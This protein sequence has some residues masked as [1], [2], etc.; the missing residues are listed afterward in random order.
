MT[1]DNFT[2]PDAPKPLSPTPAQS[3]GTGPAAVPPA[4]APRRHRWLR[5]L[6]IG[7]GVIVVLLLLLLLLLPTILSSG[8]VRSMVVSKINENLNGHVA[9]SSWKIGWT[10]GVSAD[11]VRVFDDANS[12]ILE[13]NHFSTDVSLIAAARGQIHLGH[14]VVDG[15]DFFAHRYKDGE[16][17]FA[18]L[19]KKSA[20]STTPGSSGGSSSSSSSKLPSI[21]GKVEIT[22]SRG[23]F[24][25]DQTNQTVLIKSLGGTIDIPSINDPIQESLKVVA[26]I[27]AG[28]DGTIT[29]D[30][31]AR[32]ASQ[33]QL[34]PPAQMD[35]QQ[36]LAISSFE[37]AN[38]LP[39]LPKSV[40]V[41]TLA[42]RTDGMINIALAQGQAT[43]S[44][45]VGITG[46][47]AGGQALKG[48]TFAADSLL[49]T[50][51][52]TTANLPGGNPA[53]DQPIRIGSGQNDAITL[54]IVSTVDGKPTQ[55][56]V[57]LSADAT[58]AVLQNVAAMQAPGGSGNVRLTA[59][60]DAR[61]VAGLPHL[62][63][64]SPG[65]ALKSGVV[66]ETLAVTFNKDKALLDE[67]LNVTGVS[68]EDTQ[69]N[70]SQTITLS[71][72]G[73]T[74]KAADLGAGAGGKIPD[75]R[76]ISLDLTTGEREQGYATAQIHGAN[77]SSV[78]GNVHV[79]LDRLQKEWGQLVD[80]G[81]LQLGGVIDATLSAKGNLLP[82]L[83]KP[84]EKLASQANVTV[85]AKDLVVDGVKPGK[86][87][88]EPMLN[89]ALAA[90]L[91]GGEP[92]PTGPAATPARTSPAAP[93]LVSSIDGFQFT[94][95]T[96][97]TT[98]PTV[99]MNIAGSAALSPLA[100]DL[101]I[102][103]ILVNPTLLQQELSALMPENAPA[104]Q[105]GIVTLT[106]KAQSASPPAGKGGQSTRASAALKVGIFNV[107]LANRGEK[108]LD[109]Y[110]LKSEIDATYDADAAGNARILVSRLSATDD[111][112]SP[113]SMLGIE[114]A[115]G[116]PIDINATADGKM[117]GNGAL[118][119]DRLN[120]ARL[121][122]LADAFST[123][124][125]ATA[126]QQP[127]VTNGVAAG[128]LAFSTTDKQ[129]F[130]ADVTLGVDHLAY[131]VPGAR[132]LT[133][134]Q[135]KLALSALATQN[136]AQVQVPQCQVT[137]SVATVTV[138]NTQV[139]LK[140][141]PGKD[142]RAATPL[143][144][145]RQATV[146][147]VIPAL[148]AL[149]EKLDAITPP[150]PAA[151]T[152]DA[153]PIPGSA[154]AS[155]DRFGPL[156]A[157]AKPSKPAVATP[158]PPTKLAGGSA[159]ISLA[160]SRDNADQMTVTPS[161]AC[162]GVTLSKDG[163]PD[164]VGDVTLGGAIA[165]I[166]A[167][168]GGNAAAARALPTTAP[169][170][171][172]SVM[173]QI[174]AIR[175]NALSFSGAGTTATVNGAVA[176]LA[177]ARTLQNVA[178]DLS[179]DAPTL[180][181]VVLPMLSKDQQ[182]KLKDAQVTGNYTKHIVVNGSYPAGQEF[183]QAVTHVNASGEIALDLFN[184]EG[185]TLK[186]FV[187]PFALA[188]GKVR[189]AFADKP[190]GQDAPAP[191]SFN[192][193]KLNL[194]GTVVDL[195]DPHM[196]LTMPPGTTLI[197]KANLN[198]VL[199]ANLGD[200]IN[201]PLFAG[202]DQASGLLTVVINQCNQLPTDSEMNVKSA[203]NKGI[204]DANISVGSLHLGNAALSKI[205]AF[206]HSQKFG[207]SLQGELKTLHVHIQ[208]GVTTNDMELDLLES[209][210]PLKLNGTV[211]MA[212]RQ[213]HMNLVLPPALF[214]A[215]SLPGIGEEGIQLPLSGP[216]NA[217]T[218]D[219]P[220]AVQKNILSKPQDL[221]KGLVNP[222]ANSGNST[223]PA[224]K[225]ADAVNDLIN[226]FGKKKKKT[227][228]DENPPQQ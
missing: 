171:A 198:S 200:F 60:F 117:T 115:E 191:A 160:V 7:L 131:V 161:G 226:I 158:T 128:S 124:T 167:P 63:S 93:P 213:M 66:D 144:M 19:A 53:A 25:D 181:K 62:L 86:S 152:A 51:P 103:E 88:H 104:F 75:L 28:S 183:S 26:A 227:P 74:L 134:E 30:G 165:I 166:P 137:T 107:T 105:G 48:D 184:G 49:L 149:Q 127:R 36:A 89:L 210:R 90:S 80:F 54:A 99:R 113:S 132:G 192:D 32:V 182:A 106:G 8:P 220:G 27:G 39:M 15:L 199:A 196:T 190:Q 76:D 125:P 94:L 123:P 13:L 209:K 176:D 18:R 206:T 57:A 147:I 40:G 61:T 141:G 122:A 114:T 136:F 140:D 72:I 118:Q 96:R 150:E 212:S 59:H 83:A 11:G 208:E 111:P 187:F 24:Q 142:A 97:D 135:V 186:Q 214:G 126:A 177:A 228:P 129:E 82:E 154:V 174:G 92:A 81:P 119:I 16:L 178:I 31:K 12:Q 218:F 205:L 148:A 138:A 6:G 168:A 203:D 201:N 100:V 193:G 143:E 10:G 202:A 116:K 22:N 29:L 1:Q 44:G 43:A 78:D 45:K 23:T 224:E 71:P 77:L 139:K 153:G 217:P 222:K 9:I 108:A 219:L 189:V 20:A 95:L 4:A 65:V 221:I 146:T 84:G 175:F 151:K 204:L 163:V 156:Y 145:V 17:N 120:L 225:P 37:L 130:K 87:I 164:N 69:K 79:V 56:T 2:S 215:G 3:R 102:N 169:A 47:K 58:P 180:W 85:S 35:I 67:R 33:N 91:H 121:M 155:A 46:L 68:A 162:K 73:L 70:K 157:A 55:S 98:N 188:G 172:P 109:N 50:I 133:D 5:R 64:L 173:D 159:N 207:N 101:A 216:V 34:L 197:E 211:E 194:A 110:T 52:T 42:G 14:T 223:Q 21:D 112:A 195:S 38:L 41:A 179:Y 170:T 185:I